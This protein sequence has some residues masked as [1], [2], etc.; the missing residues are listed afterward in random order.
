M[1]IKHK[2]I[3]L[4]FVLFFS[5]GEAAN[6]HVLL[7][8]DTLSDLREQVLSDLGM[9][10]HQTVQLSH[11]LKASPKVRMIKDQSVSRSAVLNAIDNLEVQ[12]D[13]YLL[14]YYS[15]HGCRTDQKKSP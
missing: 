4:L 14:F 1:K 10:H 6:F 5:F 11:I 12:P 2:L 15:G 7:V 9:M 13:D 8:G 3:T